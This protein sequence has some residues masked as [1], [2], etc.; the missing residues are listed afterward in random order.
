MVITVFS[1]N[2]THH[3]TSSLVSGI[4]I[5]HLSYRWWRAEQLLKTILNRH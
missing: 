1:M 2:I 5:Q 3:N 4:V